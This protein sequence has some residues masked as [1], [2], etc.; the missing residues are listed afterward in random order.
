MEAAYQLRLRGTKGT[1][2]LKT[3]SPGLVLITFGTLLAAITVLV[4]SRI[5]VEAV[6][7]SSDDAAASSAAPERTP[8]AERP[9]HANLPPPL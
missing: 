8:E 5:S 2:A 7:S 4:Q 3:S 9:A 6:D 1:S